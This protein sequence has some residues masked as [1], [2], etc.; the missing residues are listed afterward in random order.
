MTLSTSKVN[1]RAVEA[2]EVRVC[3]PGLPSGHGSEKACPGADPKPP[4]IGRTPVPL[5]STSAVPRPGTAGLT[6]TTSL[7]KSDNLHVSWDRGSVSFGGT[8]STA[9][10]RFSKESNQKWGGARDSLRGEQ[11][12]SARGV[13]GG[14]AGAPAQH[15]PPA[16]PVPSAGEACDKRLC[17][18]HSR[19]QVTRSGPAPFKDQWVCIRAA[20]GPGSLGPCK[21]GRPSP[22]CPACAGSSGRREGL[23]AVRTQ[24]QVTP[25][26]HGSCCGG[27]ESGRGG[28][29][30]HGCQGSGS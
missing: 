29:G 25:H 23:Q 5:P 15:R 12:S 8:E 18:V 21:P 11:A 9:F 4:G 30:A 16:P 13:D 20:G 22:G 28:A 6:G 7:R 24:C 10:F 1:R 3:S 27:C 14:G 17:H 19:G 2:R 26:A